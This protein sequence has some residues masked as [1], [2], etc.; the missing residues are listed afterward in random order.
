[1]TVGAVGLGL[2]DGDDEIVG[3][4]V[5]VGCSVGDGDGRIGVRAGVEPPP[6][7]HAVKIA[8]AANGTNSERIVTTSFRPPEEPPAG[9]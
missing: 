3:V 6:P 1:M 4:L 5:G 2:G 7:L 8:T 9:R